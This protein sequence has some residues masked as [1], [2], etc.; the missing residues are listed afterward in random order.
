M[1][2]DNPTMKELNDFIRALTG[3]ACS[4]IKEDRDVMVATQKGA[5]ERFSEVAARLQ[6]GRKYLRALD[7]I[8]E[9]AEKRI[10]AVAA[11]SF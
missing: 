10:C 9:G 4:L 7:E 8:F 11:H 2:N 1:S 5:P 6:K 3:D